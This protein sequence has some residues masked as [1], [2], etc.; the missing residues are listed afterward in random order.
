MAHELL[1]GERPGLGRRSG[2]QPGSTRSHGLPLARQVRIDPRDSGCRVLQPAPAAAAT[3]EGRVGQ[4]YERDVDASL[5]HGLRPARVVHRL[6]QER[7]VRKA[8]QGRGR[9]SQEHEAD[10]GSELCVHLQER[11]LDQREIGH[12]AGVA[13]KADDDGLPGLPQRLAPEGGM[14]VVGDDMNR[15]RV[16]RQRI[17]QG[18]ARHQDPGGPAHQIRD[19]RRTESSLQ[20]LAQRAIG[21]GQEL[22]QIVEDGLAGLQNSTKLRPGRTCGEEPLHQHEIRGLDGVRVDRDLRALETC[23]QQ[24]LDSIL[25]RGKGSEDPH[26]PGLRGLGL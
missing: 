19:I 6:R 25:Q 18:G 12:V 21:L 1:D 7:N 9:A 5:A 24:Q 10:P 16:R 15:A 22:V 4:G 14:Q 20:M 17:A 2:E 3:V 23:S 8:F 11:G 13:R 26:V